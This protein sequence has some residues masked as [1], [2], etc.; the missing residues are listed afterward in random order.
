MSTSER[1]PT[2]QQRFWRR[3]PKSYRVGIIVALFGPFVT[4][5]ATSKSTVNGVVTACSYLDFAK[6]GGAAVLVVL[7]V[8]GLI[9]NR[10]S[11]HPLPG[12]VATLL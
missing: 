11:A 12:W 5:A 1:T 8:L 9:A 2:D 6:L 10:R 7:A 4:L 3:I